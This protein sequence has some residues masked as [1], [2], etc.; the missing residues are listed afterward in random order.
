MKRF[1]RT[2]A[3]AFVSTGT[4]AAATIIGTGSPVTS[5]AVLIPSLIAGALAAGHAAMPSTLGTDAPKP[6]VTTANFPSTH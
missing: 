4:V 3:H 6:S 5:G 1:I 2:L